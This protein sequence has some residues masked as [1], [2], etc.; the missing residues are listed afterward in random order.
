MFH[1]TSC[2]SWCSV[3]FANPYSL[4]LCNCLLLSQVVYWVIFV[5][6]F[7]LRL[8]FFSIAQFDLSLH[9]PSPF[10]SNASQYSF[11]QNRILSVL[12]VFFP[13]QGTSFWSLLLS[14]TDWAKVLPFCPAL[15]A[16]LSGPHAFSRCMLVLVSCNSSTILRKNTWEVDFLRL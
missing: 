5:Q 4:S 11:P 8:I 14:C 15:E 7:F 3:Q 16:L 9:L 2:K 6:L 10:N 13:P 12:Q 1:L